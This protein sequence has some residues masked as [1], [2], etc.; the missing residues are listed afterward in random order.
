MSPALIFDCDGV[1][2]DTELDGHL[3]AFNEMFAEVG[4]P[5][6]WDEDEYVRLLA[7]GGGKERLRAALGA[8]IAAR[9]TDAVARDALVA[10]WHEL[11]TRLY[12]DRVLAG[13]LPARPGVRRL[14]AEAADEGWAL[15][16]ASTSAE[17]SVRAVLEHTVG[18]EMAGRFG[19]FAGEMVPRK[20]PSPDVYLLAVEALG[21]DPT[22]TVVVEDSRTGLL[23]ALAAGLPT[24]VTRNRCTVDDDFSGAS[25]VL[26]SLGEPPAEPADVVSDPLGIGVEGAVD[27]ALLRRVLA[28]S[29]R[30]DPAG[31]DGSSVRHQGLEPRTR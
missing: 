22:E 20:K 25:L 1:L 14:V 12:I 6:R 15:A 28:A 3:P 21:A 29:R 7:I 30:T 26:S 17:S 19:V 13:R 4:L 18:P 8:E 16:V 27:T 24:I 10:G 2:A 31:V 11:K 9:A 5:V 23:A